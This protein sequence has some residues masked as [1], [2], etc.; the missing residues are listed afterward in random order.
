MV[1]MFAS[2][3]Q[4]QSTDHAHLRSGIFAAAAA[5]VLF[6]AY[7]PWQLYATESCAGSMPR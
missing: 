2:L 7:L 6:A 5:V 1:F 4:V 3:V